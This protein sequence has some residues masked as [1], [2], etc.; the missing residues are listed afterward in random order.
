MRA[1]IPALLFSLLFLGGSSWAQETPE[2]WASYFI[3]E[4]VLLRG[5]DDPNL[6]SARAIPQP[7]LIL[8]STEE[9]KTKV[10]ARVGVE[11]QKRLLVDL[12]VESPRTS[13]E[14]GE[15]TLASLDGFS[16]SSTA[17]LGF[18]WMSKDPVAYAT[19]MMAMMESMSR[20]EVRRV[21]TEE[22]ARETKTEDKANERTDCI[23]KK[24]LEA[25][26]DEN[27]RFKTYADPSISP[28]PMKELG[29]E[30]YQKAMKASREALKNQH[31]LFL[32]ARVR[33]GRNDFSFVNPSTLKALDETHTDR[34]LTAELGTYLQ[35]MFYTSLSYSRSTAFSDGQMKDLCVPFG[36]TGTLE[37]RKL[38]VEPPKRKDAEALKFELRWLFDNVGFAT[39]VH[40]DLE[41]NVTAIEL[42][43]YFLQKLGTSEMELNGGVAVKWR[44]DTKDYAVTA[45]IGPA[46]STVFRMRLQ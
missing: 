35:G 26:M 39:R 12:Q 8:E 28:S 46:L 45:F 11:I 5:A 38:T 40:R 34:K 21:A 17:E 29:P 36:N 3:L 23:D 14:S 32:S 6:D 9:G 27:R 24:T 42:P 22:C 20:E 13:E 43:L 4:E 31:P 33:A 15:T 19:D 30:L 2:D 37:C 18:T 7:K 1:P 25:K 41:D 10:K 44:S 16:D